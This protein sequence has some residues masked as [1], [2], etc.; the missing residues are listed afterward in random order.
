MSKINWTTKL[1]AVFFLCAMAGTALPA[2]T[3]TTLHSFDKKDGKTP[4]V[5]LVQG[6]D[7]NFYGT[8][9]Y[10]GANSSCDYGAGCGTAF[11][12]TPSGKL[13]TLYSFCE[14][15]NC[16]DEFRPNALIQSTEWKLLRHNKP[17]RG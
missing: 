9:P 6:T 8:M 16:I 2:Q 3:F 14:Q 7:G 4:F 1:G 13:T 5:G 17:Q 15:T 12:I 11:K 10:G